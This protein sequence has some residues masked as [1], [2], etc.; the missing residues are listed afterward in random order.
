MRTKPKGQDN[1]NHNVEGLEGA[2]GPKGVKRGNR[3]KG[4][5]SAVG[6]AERQ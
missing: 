2:R 1:G 6:G 5:H 3:K 4:N